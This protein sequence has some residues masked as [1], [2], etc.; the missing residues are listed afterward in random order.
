MLIYIMLIFFFAM[1]IVVYIKSNKDILNPAVI[2]SAMYTFSILCAA[3]NKEYWGIDLGVTTF[4]IIILG[5][6]EFIFISFIIN[7]YYKN[8]Y[9]KS[10][11]ELETQEE[12]KD[13]VIIIEKWKIIAILIYSIAAIILLILNVLSIA[14][15]FGEYSNFSE[16]LTIFRQNTSYESNTSLSRI[17]SLALKPLF[18]SAYVCLFVY[19]RNIIY[20]D[21]KMIKKIF[22]ESI[23]LLP[24]L[25]FVI[26]S[27]AQSNRGSILRIAL[28]GF[29]MFMI[30]WYQKGKWKCRVQLKTIIIL[31]ATACIGLT[32]FYFS[33][34]LV[35]RKISKNL[36]QYVTMYCGGSIQCLD[37]YIKNP[38]EKSG[39]FGYE[40]FTYFIINLCDYAGLELEEVPTAHLEWRRSNGILV[41]NVY[42]SYRRWIQDFGYVGMAVLQA[43]VAVFY[44]IY[45]NKIKYSKNKS[46]TIN[47]LALIMYGYLAYPLFI[48]S[49]DSVLYLNVFRVFFITQLLTL[50]LVYIFLLKTKI[51]LK[52]GLNVTI[53]NKEIIKGWKFQKISNNKSN[54]ESDNIE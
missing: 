3:I 30:I 53:Y 16:A 12:N 6:I 32:A 34:T 29:V 17:V 33:A 45:Y 54:K 31:A 2:F 22:K 8:K 37:L 13:K 24:V 48:H 49:I 39:I 10:E 35:G 36:V 1:T 38:V 11:D 4:L 41:G 43:G 21:G 27:L 14:S 23:Y 50:L 52:G 25:A 46:N 9:G 44:N 26:Q 47:D 15:E 51:S 20:K 18:A 28:A 40:T 42:T 7:R 5:G 19:I